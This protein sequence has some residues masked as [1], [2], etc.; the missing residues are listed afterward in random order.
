[1]NNYAPIF[2]IRIENPETD[3]ETNLKYIKNV[4]YRS[5]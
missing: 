2:K 4:I 5:R 3:N 1:M